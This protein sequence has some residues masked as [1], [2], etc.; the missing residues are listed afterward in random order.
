[1]QAHAVVRNG[2]TYLPH[3]P[4]ETDAHVSAPQASLRAHIG[5][6]PQETVLFHDSIAYNIRYG[7]RGAPGA[8]E[9]E[10]AARGARIHERIV[11]FEN[12]YDTEVGERGARL[13]GGEKQRV[14]IARVLL[15]SP[16]I[17]LLD[18]VLSP[19]RRGLWSLCFVGVFALL[20]LRISRA[21]S[22]PPLLSAPPCF[23]WRFSVKARP[24]SGDVRAR[25][26]DGEG[27]PARAVRRVPRSDVRRGLAPP[28]HHRG[29]GPNR[30]AAQRLHRAAGDA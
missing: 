7:A 30:R 18:E 5:V 23:P 1:M 27:G 20:V 17:L 21:V 8:A 24:F 3:A 2:R 14:A 26:S 11:S 4:R 15:H 13:S 16:E 28:Q 10:E 29:R 19:A 22:L 25:L 6:V 9:V 12:G